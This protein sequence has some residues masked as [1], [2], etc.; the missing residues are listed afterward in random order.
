MTTLAIGSLVLGGIALT[1]DPNTWRFPWPRRAQEFKGE[2]GWNV[3][4][5]WGHVL[6]DGKIV[7]GS[8]ET[9]PLDFAVMRAIKALH[10]VG[11]DVSYVDAFGNAGTVRIETF[12]EQHRAG[13]L[14]DY[15]CTLSVRALTA[16]YGD[17]LPEEVI[18]A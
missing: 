4:Q 11:A 5:D 1:A 17:D 13:T 18:V 8:G 16:L 3:W 12:D 10:L 2:G 15:T 7:M 9:G 6:K 14:W